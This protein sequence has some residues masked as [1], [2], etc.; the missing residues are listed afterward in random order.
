MNELTTVIKAGEISANFEKIKAQLQTEL[1][2]YDIV[3]T[4]DTIKEAKQSRAELNKLKDKID[5]QRKD[6]K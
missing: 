4:D 5:T 3:F 1:T 6:T 2:R